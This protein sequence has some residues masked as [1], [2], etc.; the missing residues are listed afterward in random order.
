MEFERAIYRVYEKCL[1]GLREDE[2]DSLSPRTCR[3][4]EGLVL[5]TA[6]TLLACLFFLHYQFVGSVGCLPALLSK[7][8]NPLPREM[9]NFSESYLGRSEDF[10]RNLTALDL[11]SDQILQIFVKGNFISNP[12]NSG[13][14]D[15]DEEVSLLRG[16][17][18]IKTSTNLFHDRSIRSS[19][20]QQNDSYISSHRLARP[21][22]NRRNFDYEFGFNLG[23]LG[24]LHSHLTHL[25]VWIQAQLEKLNLDPFI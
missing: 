24:N 6:L 23:L 7:F 3:L 18:L 21:S 10:H 9:S 15:E 13:S 8:P 17:D 25:Y 12:S 14:L 1:E 5:S 11:R 4:V 16:L 22:A 2:P 20:I 19:S